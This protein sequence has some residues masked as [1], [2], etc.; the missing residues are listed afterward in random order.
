MEIKRFFANQDSFDGKYIYNFFHFGFCE[1]FVHLANRA[2]IILAVVKID[3]N[4]ISDFMPKHFAHIRMKT[5][6]ILKG[7][8][9]LRSKR[10]SS[11]AEQDAH[12]SAD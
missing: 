11:A 3:D 12:M 8:I 1:I 10:A 9:A 6:S 5:N 4:F 7:L 2:I